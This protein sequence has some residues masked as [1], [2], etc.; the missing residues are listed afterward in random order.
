M[1]RMKKAKQYKTKIGLGTSVTVNFGE[2]YENIREVKSR[3]IRKDLVGHL[4]HIASA[5]FLSNFWWL[6]P[7]FSLLMMNSY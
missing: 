3:R 7:V 6:V 1:K 2:T 4:A 5:L